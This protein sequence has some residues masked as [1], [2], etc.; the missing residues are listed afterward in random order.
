MDQLQGWFWSRSI[1]W[2]ACF[3][4]YVGF[5]HVSTS[6]TMFIGCVFVFL[7]TGIQVVTKR[8]WVSSLGKARVKLLVFEVSFW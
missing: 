6:Q 5:S 4:T 8:V 3:T 1:C 2:R 7:E